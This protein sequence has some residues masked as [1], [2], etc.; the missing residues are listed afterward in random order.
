MLRMIIFQ[1]MWCHVS[2]CI[3]H[4]LSQ[5]QGNSLGLW[6]HLAQISFRLSVDDVW[7]H[8]FVT[9]EFT[10][11]RVHLPWF[12]RIQDKLY[13]IF[14]LLFKL[15]IKINHLWI[16]YYCLALENTPIGLPEFINMSF[17]KCYIKYSKT[18]I[19][20]NGALFFSVITYIFK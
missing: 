8:R 7:R 9:D 20:V 12:Q 17:Y 2:H 14:L 11:F 4:S 16:G 6:E 13:E 3:Q 1:V 18:W 5:C 19:I 10:M 15:K